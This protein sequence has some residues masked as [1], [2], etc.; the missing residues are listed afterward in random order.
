MQWL[1]MFGFGFVAALLAGASPSQMP[2][3]ET[4][5]TGS[6]S[7]PGFSLVPPPS[8]PRVKERTVVASFQ[9]GVDDGFISNVN[10]IVDP[11]K[12]TL[13]EFMDKSLA[14]LNGTNPKAVYKSRQERKVSGKDAEFLD[15][16]AS[17]NQRRL[18]F[19]QLIVVDEERV[20]IVTCTSPADTIAHQKEFEDCINSF[21]LAGK[22]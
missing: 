2:P 3:A 6:E 12:T 4:S 7:S 9:V 16:E 1:K 13:K 10:V 8:I 22:Q 5:P 18:R 20:F 21:R 19:M 11:I 14:E 17:L 15:F